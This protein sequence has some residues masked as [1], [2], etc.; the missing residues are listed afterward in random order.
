MVEKYLSENPHFLSSLLKAEAYLH[1]GAE[2][3]AKLELKSSLSLG[4]KA[5]VFPWYQWLIARNFDQDKWDHSLWYVNQLLKVFPGSPSLYQTKAGILIHRQDYAGAAR[6]YQKNIDLDGKSALVREQYARALLHL[7]QWDQ[8]GEQYLQAGDMTQD[9]SLYRDASNA[10]AKAK[11]WERVA[12]CFRAVFRILPQDL[13]FG[14]RRMRACMALAKWP[15]AFEVVLKKT[16]NDPHLWIGKGRYHLLQ[17]QWKEANEAFSQI[18]KAIPPGDIWFELAGARLLTGNQKG[19]QSFCNRM[20]AKASDPPTIAQAY[21]LARTFSLTKRSEEEASQIVRWAA[22]ALKQNP[23]LGWYKHAMG[24]AFYRAQQYKSAIKH[25][26]QSL[27]TS[28]P[29]RYLNYLWLS[30]C[31]FQL[32][33]S[34]KAQQWH[35]RGI[36]ALKAIDPNNPSASR[37]PPPPDWLEG[38]IVRREAEAL[39]SK[40]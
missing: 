15:E 1:L 29:E 9:P 28:W 8:A 26:N 25:F 32:H 33:E 13:R 37:S 20:Q 23:Q 24:M 27:A 22:H 30:M 3:K 21:Q 14:S 6:A 2:Q 19:Y 38:E 36:R 16:P 7:E 12:H 40:P 10:F 39:F 34:D 11:K 31:H 5:Q 4:A 17:R 35:R 18:E